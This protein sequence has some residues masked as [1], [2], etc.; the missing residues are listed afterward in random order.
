MGRYSIEDFIQ[1]TEEKDLD[2]GIFELERERLLEVN[3]EGMVWTKRGS[4][5]AYT[6]DIVFTREGVFE[7]GIGTFMKKAL[8]GEGVSLTKAEGK[9]KLYLAD[10]GKKVSVL[11]L[12]NESLF[13]NGN[14]LLAFETSLNW[15]IKMMKSVSGMMAGGL[16]NIKLEGTGMAAI[17]T[18]QDP[19]TLQVSPSHPV[20]TDPN[21]TVA[22]S[23]NLEPEIKTDISLKTLVGRSSGE[24]FQMAFKGEGFV[25]VQPYEEVYF[26]TQT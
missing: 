23:G 11:K 13:V 1:N 7:H 25:V 14:D 21:A 6:G 12:E 9:G 16:F 10:E 20:F 18:H 3:L 26:Q 17:T 2:Q 15:N 5:V 8:T 22:W 24:S 4:M 19:L